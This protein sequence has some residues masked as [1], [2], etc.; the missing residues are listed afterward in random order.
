MVPQLV[1]LLALALA[2]SLDG[3]GVGAM[4]GLRKIKIPVMSVLIIAVMSGLVFFA[5]MQIGVAVTAYIPAG[6]AKTAGAV[7]LIGLGFWAI[8][9]MKRSGEE[10][11]A[12]ASPASAAAA[13]SGGKQ[14]DGQEARVLSIELKRLGLVIQILRTPSAADMDRSG[15][16]SAMEAA[17]LGLALSLDA[18]GAGIGAAFIGYAPLLTSA[19][20]AVA[21][22]SFIL[23]GLRFGFMYSNVQWIRKLSVLPGCIL[24]LMGLFRL[25]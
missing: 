9:Q 21:S 19:V 12:E 20:I 16:I 23:G 2:V 24:M 14:G 5:A 17:W 10:E 4:Y 22:G 8:I 1:S 3:F 25:M 6:V 15:N 13:A 18:F 7:I 11:K